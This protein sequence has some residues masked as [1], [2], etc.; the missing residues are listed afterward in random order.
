MAREIVTRIAD[1]QRDR[2]ALQR[3]REAVFVDEQG[4]SAELEWD[5]KD[6]QC[7]HAL[8]AIGAVEPVATGRLQPDGKIG[9]MA[10]L[11]EWRGRGL[12][13]AILDELVRAAADSGLTTVYLHAQTHA[14]P[15]YERAGFVAEGPEFDEAGIPH[16]LMR[17]SI[18]SE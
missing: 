5:G 2:P 18:R 9:R 1:W 4:V 15:F 7:L 10:V 13:Q 6:A 17:R 12:G 11:R 3:I 14:M 16:R 8:A